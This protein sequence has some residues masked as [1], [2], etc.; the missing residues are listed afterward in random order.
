[1][2]EQSKTIVR[3]ADMQQHREEA[4]VRLSHAAVAR[5]IPCVG[6]AHFAQ[7]AQ[8]RTIASAASAAAQQQQHC[9]V[10]AH[11]PTA[12]AS[13]ECQGPAAAAA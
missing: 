9:A 5:S 1:M 12:A 13:P 7:H 4:Q 6:R 10:Q 11:A 8:C 3:T 2:H